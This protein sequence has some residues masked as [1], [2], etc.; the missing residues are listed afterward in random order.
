VVDH[1]NPKF[2]CHG[3]LEPGDIPAGFSARRKVINAVWLTLPTPKRAE[4]KF[5]THIK[6][7]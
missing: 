1:S 7:I 6:L 2:T 3:N 4:G 5:S